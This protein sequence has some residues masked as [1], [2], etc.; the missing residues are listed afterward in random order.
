MPGGVPQDQLP[1]VIDQPAAPVQLGANVSDANPVAQAGHG[2]ADLLYKEQMQADQTA[3]LKATNQLAD[4]DNEKLYH[5]ERGLLNQNLG[6]SAPKAADKVLTDY[7]EERSKIRTGLT[8]D[9]Q[10]DAF[11]QA[12]MEHMRT[13]RRQVWSYELGQQKQAEAQTYAGAMENAHTAAVNTYDLPSEIAPEDTTPPKGLVKA[14]N[15]DLT[16]RPVVK[17][18]DGSISTVRSISFSEDGK[19][20]LVP[21]VSDDGRIMSDQE[22]IA[23]YHAT[24]KSLG[25]FASE[26]DATAYAKTLHEN[27]AKRYATIDPLTHQIDKQEALTRDFGRAQG[28]PGALITAKVAEA[29]SRTYTSVIDDMLAKDNIGGAQQLFNEHGTDIEPQQR[30]AVE[31]ALRTS[32]QENTAQKYADEFLSRGQ[33]EAPPTRQAFFERLRSDATLRDDAKLYDAVA[34]RGESY[35]D[36]R[37]GAKVEG[38]RNVQGTIMKAVAQDPTVDPQTTVTPLQWESLEGTTQESL[39]NYWRQSLKKDSVVRTD[40][41]AWSALDQLMSDPRRKDEALSVQMP[42]YVDKLD[43]ADYKA[44]TARQNKIREGSDEMLTKDAMINEIAGNVMRAN[45]MSPTKATPQSRANE[46]IYTRTLKE[47]IRSQEAETGKP[48]NQAQVQ[49]LADKLAI[50]VVTKTHWFSADET[51][52]TAKV[53]AGNKFPAQP[54][55]ENATKWNES[56]RNPHGDAFDGNVSTLKRWSQGKD[57]LGFDDPN[58]IAHARAIVNTWVSAE[59]RQKIVDAYKEKHAGARPTEA[60]I[61]GTYANYLKRTTPAIHV[62]EVSQ[63]PDYDASQNEISG[64]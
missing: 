62:A 28:W 30:V 11:D 10:R 37:D 15:V 57:D 63:V 38:Q 55:P 31:K 16:N 50:P 6:S 64:P 40:L 60:D 47:Q 18:A 3:A 39:K 7:G 22:A 35:F 23:H 32:S 19:E 42:D 52:T 25:E 24:G 56:L 13:V 49:E 8:S 58:R 44:F 34:R 20:I 4:L 5:P 26:A 51:Q 1:D 14:G 36:M 46:A 21:T 41:T 53:I 59:N 2:V 61:I 43:Q 9:R 45:L 54:K 48:M 12:S 27:Q 17:N 33:G 29:K